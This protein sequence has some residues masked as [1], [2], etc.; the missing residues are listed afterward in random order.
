MSMA[1]FVTRA[2]RDPGESLAG[3]RVRLVGFVARPSTPTV[4]DI[5]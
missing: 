1:E 3:V 2:I 4:M 5:G